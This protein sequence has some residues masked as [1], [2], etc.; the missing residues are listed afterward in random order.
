MTAFHRI[1][2]LLSGKKII[3][4]ARSSWTVLTGYFKGERAALR[5]LNTDE[6]KVRK[7]SRQLGASSVCVLKKETQSKT[8]KT[9]NPK[10]LDGENSQ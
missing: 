4:L 9:Q 8:S 6:E 5:C 1:F 3:D 7:I 10:Q 2:L